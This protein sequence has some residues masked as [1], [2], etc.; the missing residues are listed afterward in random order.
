[1]LPQAGV[2]F[3]NCEC[4]LAPS[5]STSTR[6]D[7]TIVQTTR[8]PKQIEETGENILLLEYSESV[9]QMTRRY[10][11]KTSLLRVSAATGY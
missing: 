9:L 3:L 10:I 1:M 8:W 6:Y 11:T 2:Q 5:N 7:D 4:A